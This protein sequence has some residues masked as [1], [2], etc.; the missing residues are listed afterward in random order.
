MPSEVRSPRTLS[1]WLELDY[2]RRRRLFTGWWR[3]VLGGAVLGG[4][5]LAG[6]YAATGNKA[7]QAGPVTRP[8]ALFNHDCGRCH[9][10][11]FA[12]IARLWQG[13]TVGSVT[14]GACLKCHEGSAHNHP[15]GG[16]V[17]RC[18]ECHK[19]HRGH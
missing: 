6:L 15:H 4:L 10:R 3:W 8:H 16:E 18:V 11:T 17:G 19:E 1:S 2:H 12:T 5:A 9:E 7:F 13:D 14:N